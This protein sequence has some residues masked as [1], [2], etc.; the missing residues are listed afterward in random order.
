MEVYEGLEELKTILKYE[1]I[2]A[3]IRFAQKAKET[4]ANM[5]TL[6]TVVDKVMKISNLSM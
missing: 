5:H 1:Y 3:V 6:T 2:K 4:A